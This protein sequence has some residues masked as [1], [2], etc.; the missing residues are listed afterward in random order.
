MRKI[1]L[2]AALGLFSAV[3][4]QAQDDDQET[5]RG[6]GK[7]VTRDVPVTAFTSLKASGVYE[8]KLL[9]GGSES[10]KIEADGKPSSI[11]QG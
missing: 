4:V 9:Q 7:L 6:N 3:A 2:T 10:V 11:F 5:V 8:L 1:L